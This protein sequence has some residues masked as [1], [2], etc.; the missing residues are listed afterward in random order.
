[1]AHDPLKLAVNH[2]VRDRQAYITRALGR[3]ADAKRPQAWQEYGYPEQ[4]CF[5]DFFRLYERHGVAH[6]VV[7]RLVEKCWETS[8]RVIEGD[9]WDDKTPETKWEAEFGKLAKR[10]KLW[11]AMADADVRRLVGRYSCLILQ[12]ADGKN[13]DQP[14]NQRACVIKVLPAWQGQMKPS[15]W[16]TNPQSPE[17]GEPTMW[18]YNEAKVDPNIEGG[19]PER[20]VSIH[21][22]RVVVVG[23]LRDGVPFL[24]AGYNDFV[25][26]EKILG[27][28]GE[29]FLKN[30]ARQLAVQYD[31]DVNLGDI[32]RSYGVALDE[33]QVAF[34]DAARDLNQGLDV[35]MAVQGGTVNPLVAAVADPEPHFNVALQSACASVR[36]PA[37]VVVGMQTGERASV[38]DLRDFNKR[39]QGRRVQD[40]SPDI[41][42]LVNHLVRYKLLSAPPGEF[43]VIWDDLTESTVIEKLAQ[44]K[45][46]ALINREFIGSGEPVPFTAAEVRDVAGFDAA[47]GGELP[48]LEDEEPDDAA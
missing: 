1:M 8:P 7:H 20:S 33:L 4:L 6:G 39:G 42:S 14:V 2:A 26:L 35:L 28:S 37:K 22:S 38:E 13:W 27:G 25:N 32:A 18:D 21:P 19:T 40:L 31:K 15:A 17:Y 23:D 48:P 24:K 46:M 30:A 10:V 36:I 3:A 9:E 16:N 11:R 12:V 45:E 43:S 34:N 29:S 5:D 41:E 47:E 44:A